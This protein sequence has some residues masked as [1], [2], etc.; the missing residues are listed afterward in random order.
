MTN[1]KLAHLNAL[2]AFE[3]VARHLSF[4]KAAS[5]LSVT[6]GAISQQVKLLEDYYG[7]ELF[8][9]N[10]RQISL[11]D[12]AA[13]ILPELS[14][15][16][17]LLV[18]AT[19]RLQS[20]GMGGIVSV[21]VPPTFAV[22]WLAQRLGDFTLA[23]PG[24]QIRVE[25]TER[26][27]DLRREQADI[28][29]RYGDGLWDGHHAD[30]LFDERLMPVCSPVYLEAHPM[31]SLADLATARLIQDRTMLSTRLD[32]PDWNS[33]LADVGVEA[34]EEGALQFSSS[35]AAIQAA[36]DGHGVILGRS[37]LIGEEL[38]SGRLIAPFKKE[39]LSGYGYYVLTVDQAPLAPRV[40]AFKQWLLDEV[41]R[42]ERR[43]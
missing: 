13:A 2:R 16:F 43:G 15:A 22:K 27:V 18:R 28:A 20:Q 1:K 29:I 32:F 24:V 5:E 19:T 40:E 31:N 38:K 39:S 36:I 25:S 3:A 35:L 14:T 11:T 17:D 23:H 12:Q 37:A 42:Y 4:A 7:V 8:R 10:G 34:P 33:W 6:P 9:R 41:E 21:T 26:L 30:H